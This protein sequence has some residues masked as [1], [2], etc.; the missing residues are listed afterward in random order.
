MMDSQN[1]HSQTPEAMFAFWQQHV[2]RED[3][4]Y[5]AHKPRTNVI[6]LYIN[7]IEI[8]WCVVLPDNDDVTAETCGRN[9]NCCVACTV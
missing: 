4:P 5:F 1:V 6:V 7:I 8:N 9:I 3:D 2:A